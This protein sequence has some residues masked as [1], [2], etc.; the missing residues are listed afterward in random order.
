MSN[1]LRGPAVE[2]IPAVTD[3]TATPHHHAWRRR[4]RRWL[5]FGLI[6]T[7]APASAELVLSGTNDAQAANIRLLSQLDE[8]ECDAAPWLIRFR[9]ERLNAEIARALEGLGFYSAT[10]DTSLRFD[11]TCWRAVADIAPGPPLLLREFSYRVAG[12]A[13][14]D[15]ALGALAEGSALVPDAP[16]DHAA[17]GRLKRQV[18]ALAAERGYFDGVFR[19]AAIDVYRDLNVADVELDFD[20]G[21]RYHFGALN[22]EQSLLDEEL[23]RRYTR[24]TQGEPYSA[25][26][27]AALSD[28]LQSSGYFNQVIVEPLVPESYGPVN[29]VARLEGSGRAT[30]SV[31]AGYSTDVG[32][33]LR[34]GYEDRRVNS[35][36]HQLS[37]DLIASPVVSELS[38]TYRQ[39]LADPTVEWLS[40]TVG[41]RGE[42]TDTAEADSLTAGIRRIRRLGRGWLRTDSL[43]LIV[44]DYTVGSVEDR[45]RLVMPGTAISRERSD[46]PINPSRGYRLTLAVR[47]TARAIGANT[48]FLQVTADGKWITSIGEHYRLIARTSLGLT[49]ERNFEELPPSVRFFAGGNESVRG[50]AFETLGPTNADGVVVGG[51]QLAVASLEVDRHIA[52][53]LALAAFVDAGNAFD[54]SDIDARVAA[55]LGIKWRSPV[56]PLRFYVA[57]PLNDDDARDVRIHVSLGPDL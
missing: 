35:R 20:S 45:A 2:S 4:W 53:N 9:F 23:V 16:F 13:A 26:A 39:P 55:G 10:W 29:V 25:G 19:R 15:P 3:H 31:G 50:F 32:P 48:R 42:D 27:L 38:A 28:R 46:D 6:A 34:V 1:G 43:E 14:A 24:W 5:A 33:R 49:A 47:G 40:Y 56:G 44:S 51:T 11:E 18:T 36:G 8:L 52:G 12:E 57:S 41:I 21:A 37:G 22:I 54:G 7:V 17:Y 30:Y